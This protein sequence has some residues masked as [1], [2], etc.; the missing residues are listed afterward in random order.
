MRTL[1]RSHIGKAM[2]MDRLETGLRMESWGTA[3]IKEWKRCQDKR[4][5]KSNYD[6]LDISNTYYVLGTVL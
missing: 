5:G 1:E 6:S 2:T 4:L 3:K